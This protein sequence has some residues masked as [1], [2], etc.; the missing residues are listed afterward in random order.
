MKTYKLTIGEKSYEVEVEKF[1]G[2]EAT[3]KVDGRPF[4]VAVEK[5]GGAM[6]GAISSTP[7]ATGARRPAPESQEVPSAPQPVV[8]AASVPSGGQVIAPMPGLILKVMV[9]S[10]DSVTAGL[11]VVKMEAMKME[12]EIPA[13]VSGRVKEVRVKEGDRVQT[14][15]LLLVIEEE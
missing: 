1:D 4:S 12:N 5:A 11:P 13:P 3:V 2:K 6:P 15:E 7:V 14:D 10:G 8:P 9:S